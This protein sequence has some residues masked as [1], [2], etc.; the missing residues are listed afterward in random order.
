MA[1]TISVGIQKGGVGKSTTSSILCYYLSEIE[2]KRVLAVDMDGQGNL[3]QLLTGIEDLFEIDGTTV[4]DAIIER[5]ASPYVLK[6]TDN[7]HILGGSENVNTLS[8]HFYIERN[9]RFHLDLKEALDKVRNDYDFI[10]IDNPPAL[11]ELS[12]ISLATSDLVVVAFETSKFCYNSLKSYLK[13]IETVQER[14]N[15]DLQIAGILRSMIDKRRTDN[16]YYADLVMEEFKNLCFQT[17]I[18]RSAVVGRVPAL[19][20]M[21][22]PETKQV[23]KHY[24]PFIKE[25]LSHVVSGQSK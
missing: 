11:G 10:I 2:K 3:T 7:L 17:I 24:K 20:L 23:I 25:L 22:N 4:Y 18:T 6:V 16:K 14:L 19:G 8:P 12:I 21:N 9:G 15:P 13:T 1:T 5:D